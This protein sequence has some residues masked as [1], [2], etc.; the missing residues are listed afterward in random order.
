VGKFSF[1]IQIK[2]TSQT[3][4]PAYGREGIKKAERVEKKK[5][6]KKEEKKSS[7]IVS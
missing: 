2:F 3:A 6:G 1:E 7:L 5:K 4:G